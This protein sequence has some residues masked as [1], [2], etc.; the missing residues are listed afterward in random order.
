MN[1]E[2]Q[3]LSVTDALTGLHN[4]RHFE[5]LMQSEIDL[6]VR[7]GDTNSIIL[8]DVDHFK[9]IN[10][11]YGHDAGDAVLESVAT[12]IQ[13]RI[14][15]TD[16]ACRFGGDEFF[17]LCRRTAAEGA[18]MIAESLRQSL[19][20]RKPKVVDVEIDVTLSIGVAT[21]PSDH[22]ITNADEFFRCADVALY[23]SKSAGRDR[24]THYAA[25]APMPR[26]QRLLV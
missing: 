10:D 20:L 7:N 9:T 1:F 25:Q 15:K 8:L 11:Q 13:S 17:I 26:A 2:L 4:R 5:Q 3:R 12:A 19:A 14:R 24:V 18:N 22:Q 6:S 23:Q 16:I 21:T